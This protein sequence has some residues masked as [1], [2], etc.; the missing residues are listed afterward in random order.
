MPVARAIDRWRTAREAGFDTYW[1]G[2]N[3]DRV[4]AKER[5]HERQ[6]QQRPSRPHQRSSQ[7]S[8]SSRWQQLA[9]KQREPSPPRPEDVDSYHRDLFE[10]SAV[11]AAQLAQQRN[12]KERLIGRLLRREVA[13]AWARWRDAVSDGKAL[14]RLC[15]VRLRG[16]RLVKAWN[17]WLDLNQARV[18]ERDDRY[19]FIRRLLNQQ[20]LSGWNTWSA[21]VHERAAAVRL[22]RK[23]LSRFVHHEVAASFGRWVEL[24]DE[25]GVVRRALV[26]LNAQQRGRAMRTWQAVCA[27]RRHVGGMLGRALRRLVNR[28]VARAWTRWA[29]VVDLRL[30][31]L[32]QRRRILGHLMHNR[33]S[34]GLLRWQQ[35]TARTQAAAVIASMRMRGQ[36]RALRTWYDVSVA[37]VHTLR[38]LRLA[39]GRW[40][41]GQ[42]AAVL[43]RWRPACKELARLRVV[44]R[45]LSHLETARAWRQWDEV[46]CARLDAYGRARRAVASLLHRRVR[47]GWSAWAA[48]TEERLAALDLLHSSGCSLLGG[49]RTKAW[50]TWRA[51]AISAA[52]QLAKLRGRAAHLVHGE[53]ACAYRTWAHISWQLRSGLTVLRRILQ[54][55]AV[56]ALAW[57]HEYSEARLGALDRLRGASASW[58]HR[59]LAAALRGWHALAA[60][61][62]DGLDR[63]RRAAANLLCRQVLAAWR[64]WRHHAAQMGGVRRIVRRWKSS[65]LAAAVSAWAEHAAEVTQSLRLLRRAASGLG[66][67]TEFAALHSWWLYTSEGRAPDAE[68]PRAPPTALEGRVLLLHAPERRRVPLSAADCCRSPSTRL[69]GLARDAELETQRSAIRQ[70]FRW[71]LARAWRQMRAITAARIVGL[72]RLRRVA[73]NAIS[74]RLAVG[75]RTWCDAVAALTLALERLERSLSAMANSQL[76]AAWRS[77][78]ITTEARAAAL[79]AMAHAARRLLH[80]R[81]AAGW[82]SWSDFALL[83]AARLE[84]LLRVGC[85]LVGRQLSRAWHAWGD[86]VEAGTAQ[87]HARRQMTRCLKRLSN[88]HLSS[89]WAAWLECASSRTHALQ[90]LR[91]CGLRLRSRRLVQGWN[92]WLDANE[93]HEAARRQRLRLAARLFDRQRVAAWASWVAFA[94]ARALQAR[95]ARRLLD[96]Q[97]LACWN[98]WVAYAAEQ[99][100]R[101]LVARRLLDRQRV[102]CWN[103]WVEYVDELQRRQMIA[104]RF[105]GR[106]RLPCWNSWVAYAAEQRASKRIAGRLFGRQRVACWNT[107]AA[108][109]TEQRQHRLMRSRIAGRLVSRQRLACWNT[110]AAHAVERAAILRL[111]RKGFSRIGRQQLVPA[112]NTWTALASMQRHRVRIAGRLFGRKRVACWNTW[113]AYSTERAAVLRL[114]RKGFSRF[115]RKGVVPGWHTWVAYASL[116]RHRHRFAGRLRSRQRVACWNTWATYVH[117]RAAAVRLLRKGLSRFVHHEVAASFGRWVE[118][119][120]EL[121]VVRRALVQLNAQQRGRAMRT[122]QAVCAERR[123]VGGMLGRA[124]R[125]LVNREVA[126]AWTRWAHVVDLRLAALRQRRRILGHLMHNRLSMGLLRWQQNTARTQAAAVIASMRMR[127]QARALRTWYDVSVAAVHTLRLLRLA[128]GR[129]ARGQLAAALLLWQ[130][131]TTPQGGAVPATSTFTQDADDVF[132]QTLLR[133]LAHADE[134]L[135]AL[136]RRPSSAPAKSPPRARSPTTPRNVQAARST[137]ASRGWNRPKYYLPRVWKP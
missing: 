36:A 136:K 82:H 9:T 43:L 72:R 56:R 54:Q 122:W 96:R 101:Q 30:A 4:N 88:R 6:R 98:T 27:E 70:L 86:A 130:Q 13:L 46:T 63:M 109:A 45:R 64:P 52:K 22:L 78:A 104:G 16:R 49:R 60:E 79:D 87:A 91:G 48:A 17:S 119:F 68:N 44:L 81:M 133:E 8:Y 127:G 14:Y 29:H 66:R 121:G 25:L 84:Q 19:R 99:H 100:Q 12:E 125:R 55:S 23:G 131:S 61:W 134:R 10:A 93:A 102:A 74:G 137:A 67:K 58:L 33:L 51:H 5:E 39:V 28:E 108:Y 57:W 112:W 41:R 37:A 11:T 47:F 73:M 103:T 31:A 32:R 124:L 40:A 118:L 111:L 128:V 26:Q 65:A 20:K 15:A 18:A 21:Y 120:D 24:F 35:N 94:A 34:M 1:S 38:L 126:R 59:G 114:L 85:H 53:M 76:V 50:N 129:W 3:L 7:R 42:L 113:A 107:W 77:W 97:R 123:H 83:R 75:W 106:E 132:R 115:T 2:A 92:S 116:K 69:A 95:T 80:S 117:E 110:W 135:A 90:L 105:L 89:G 62:R 71:Q